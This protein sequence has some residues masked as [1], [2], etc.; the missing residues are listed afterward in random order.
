MKKYN[1]YIDETWDQSLFN[2]NKDFPYFLLCWILISEDEDKKLNNQI[3]KL[4]IDFFWTTEVILHSRDIRK[5]D[6]AFKILFD[7][8][9]KE[10]F[11]DRLELILK[12]INFEIISIWIKKEDY[13]K[14][15][16][17]SAI[18][19]YEISLSY[20]LE[21]LIFCIQDENWSVDIFV[22]KRWKK[23]DKALLEYYNMLYDK[24]TYFVKSEDF[25]NRITS[26]DFRWKYKND[27]WIQIADLCAYPLVWRIRNSKEP[28]PAFEIIRSKIYQR[29]WI[30]YWFKIHP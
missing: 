23:E 6:K 22:E 19:P 12:N 4:K 26:F 21:R 8:K 14:K 3:N 17:K 28:N 27:V 16:W 7:L 1:F 10:N 2:I 29:K 30:I 5:C 9:V 15:Y 13:I 20:M 24:W 25:K 18:N 11:Y